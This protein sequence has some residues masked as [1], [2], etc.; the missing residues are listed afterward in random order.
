MINTVHRVIPHA[1]SETQFSR[2]V[3]FLRC[4]MSW[5]YIVYNKGFMWEQTTDNAI[6]MH[7]RKIQKGALN[8]NSYILLNKYS[9]LLQAVTKLRVHFIYLFIK[10]LHTLK[11]FFS[12]IT[13]YF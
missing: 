10:L 5:F 9:T 7:T 3:A 13:K 2:I 6:K 12:S 11:L 8:A 1:I 4:V